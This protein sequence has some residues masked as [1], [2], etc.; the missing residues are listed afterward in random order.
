MM[1]SMNM[2]WVGHIPC[3]GM[4]RQEFITLVRKLEWKSLPRRPRCRW[5]NNIKMNV[6]ER[7]WDEAG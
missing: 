1:K 4:I 7:R 6:K 5:E 3:M 2:G